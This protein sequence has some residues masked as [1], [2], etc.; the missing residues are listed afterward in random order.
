[1]LWAAFWMVF[2]LYKI[3]ESKKLL[4]KERA[5]MTAPDYIDRVVKE[6]GNINT[7]SEYT[8]IVK[9]RL[10]ATQCRI[11]KTAPITRDRGA[12]IERL[13]LR[14]SQQ[15]L[16]WL[17]SFSLDEAALLD[18]SLYCCDTSPPRRNISVVRR[19]FSSAGNTFARVK[20][21]RSRRGTKG[22]KRNHLD[23]PWRGTSH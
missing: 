12:V 14:N 21:S 1:M 17:I 15:N 20:K 16:P 9:A 4:V 10:N 3:N 6:R 23:I 11:E 13:N 5:I 8:D 19:L 22:H 2:A 18:R 7:V